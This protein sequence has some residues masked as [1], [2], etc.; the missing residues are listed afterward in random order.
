[1]WCA[2]RRSARTR[3]AG[4][5]INQLI[6]MAAAALVITFPLV[7]CSASSATVADAGV[8]AGM[9]KAPQATSYQPELD[10]AGGST[11]VETKKLARSA[12]ASLE[13]AD[14]QKAAST[15]ATLA[16]TLGGQVSGEQ[17]VLNQDGS[18]PS[19]VLISVPSDKLESALQ[20]LNSVGK[21]I[22]RS[23]TSEDVSTVVADVNSRV[24]T[25]TASIERLRALS[26]KAGSVEELTALESQITSR[27]SER[28]S[29][30][31][32]QRVLA[33]RVAEAD[34][35]VSLYTQAP[36]PPEPA[37]LGF[38]AGLAAGWA[39]LVS[40]TQVLLQVVGALLPFAVVAAVVLIPVLKVWR[41]RRARKIGSTAAASSTAPAAASENSSTESE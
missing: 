16:Q 35:T 37:P 26:K 5:R 18:L 9:A 7:G 30:L 34:I 31:A 36:P 29:L 24:E 1:M 22:D 4:M 3:G 13:V 19:T 15:I 17:L 39:A 11:T 12:T 40:T 33:D 41:T 23:V 28:D 14:I 6:G 10:S 20:Q 38:L 8:D 21:T 27:S 32:Q 25:L 2:Q